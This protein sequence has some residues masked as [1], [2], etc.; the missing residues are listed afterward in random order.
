MRTGPMRS[1]TALAAL[2]ALAIASP[3]RPAET[4]FQVIVHSSNPISSVSREQLTKLF[5]KRSTSWDGG[6]PVVPVDQ[7]ETSAVREQF[8]QKALGKS[9]AAVRAY[10]Q[11]RIFSGKDVPPVERA[12]D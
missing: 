2:A 8:T 6:A 10:W 12:S 4:S 7:P 3:A 9:V 11:Q 1:C 5:L